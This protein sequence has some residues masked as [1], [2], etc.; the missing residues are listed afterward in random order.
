M[1]NNIGPMTSSVCVGV[2]VSEGG[3]GEM[4][5]LRESEGERERERGQGRERLREIER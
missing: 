4:E 1:G 2:C 3:E 5:T